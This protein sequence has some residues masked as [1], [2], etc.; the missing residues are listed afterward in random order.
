MEFKL[1]DL[2]EGVEAAEVVSVMVSEGQTIQPG[3]N[4]LELETDKAVVE[5]PCETGGKISKIHVGA[6]DRVEVGASLLTIDESGAAAAPE[7]PA[8]EP[9]APEPE[10]EKRVEVKKETP[11][12][13]PPKPKPAALPATVKTPAPAAPVAASAPS[14]SGAKRPPAPASPAIRKMARELGVDLHRVAGTGPGGR[15]V[16]SDIKT[17]VKSITTAALTG[18]GQPTCDL[19]IPPLPDFSQWGD[20]ELKPLR[21]VRRKTAEHLSLAWRVIPHVTQFDSADITDLESARK[22]F[23]DKNKG[24]PGKVTTTVLAMKA[25]VAALKTY[26][27]FNSSLDSVAGTL[28]QKNYYHIGVAVDTEAGLMVPVVRDVDKKS[29]IELAT[30]LEELAARARDR[31]IALEELR[32]GTFTISNLGGIGG[33]NFTPIV[34]YPEVAILGIARSRL[35]PVIRDGETVARLMLPLSLSYDHRV[36]DGADGARFLRDVVSMLTN[37]MQLL[38][39]E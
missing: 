17:F 22:G 30:E 6:G 10:P 27:Q 34:N 28:I 33:T 20:V 36:I 4:V 13:K 29:V 7:A 9:A 21:G 19:A 32:G 35:E 25:L 11:A 2:G 5:L 24:Q 12:P 8:E 39:G 18:G 37:P 16:D 1:P 38:L 3:D 26:P 23:V 14:D 15:I 31:K